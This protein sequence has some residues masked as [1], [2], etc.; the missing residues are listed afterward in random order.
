MERTAGAITNCNTIQMLDSILFSERHIR[1]CFTR[2]LINNPFSSESTPDHKLVIRAIQGGPSSTS[3]RLVSRTRLTHAR[4]HLS[5]TISLPCAQGIWPA[6]WLLPSEPF[7]WPNDG[8]IDIAET[9]NRS[10][11]NHACLHWGHY[12]P[13]DADKHRV[14]KNVIPDMDVRPVKFD[15]YWDEPARKLVWLVDGRPVMREEI[16]RGLRPMADWNI[17]LNVAMGGNVCDGQRPVDGTYEMVIHDM[18]M[19][20]IKAKAIDHYYSKARSGKPL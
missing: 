8:E 20:S 9:W 19:S 13:Q 14:A 18:T 15:L 17:L 7:S 3:A 12:T 1:R 2:C 10:M 6:F 11:E 4:G 5:A 16:P